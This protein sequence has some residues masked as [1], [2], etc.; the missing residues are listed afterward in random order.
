MYSAYKNF[1][2]L[3][4]CREE[5]CIVEFSFDDDLVNRKAYI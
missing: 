2:G 4:S 1:Y 5:E 3:C